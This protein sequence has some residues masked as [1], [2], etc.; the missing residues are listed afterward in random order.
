MEM[1]REGIIG[2]PYVTSVSLDTSALLV[3]KIS[4]PTPI[5][6]IK[7]TYMGLKLT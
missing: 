2:N 6:L 3:V 7:M 4:G 1:I 5:L